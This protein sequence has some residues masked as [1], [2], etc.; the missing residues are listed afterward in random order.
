MDAYT[1]FQTSLNMRKVVVKDRID[2]SDGSVTYVVNQKETMLASEK[3]ELLQMKFKSWLFEE[4]RRRKKY[5]RYYNETFNHTRLREYDGSF[6][7]FP[8]MNPAF[9]LKPYQKNAVARIL[10]SGNTLLAHCVGAGK[11][12]EMI[13]AC[14][15]LKRLGLA[16]KPLISVP[17]TLVRQMASEFLRLYP[18]AHILVTSERDFTKN[19]RKE[20]ISRLATMEYDC[21]IMSHS[22]F[23]RIPISPDREKMILQRQLDEIL[24]G[25]DELKART[26]E[27]WT[28]KQMERE[29]KSIETELKRLQDAPK[30]D[31]ICFEELGIDCIFID[32]AHIY[33]NCKIFSKMGNIPGIT[34]AASKRA[35]D[36]LAKCQ[37]L[38]ECTP[39][40]GVILATGTPVSNSICEMY[41]MQ[42]YL[43]SDKLSQMGLQQFD[44]WAA[45]YGETTTALELAVE[46]NGYRFKTRFNRFKNLPEL[47]TMFREIADVQTRD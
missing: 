13:A 42:R 10:L 2:H 7:T 47:L 5:V 45:T 12:F 31:V 26:G 17:K 14:M 3:Q 34:S 38:N 46:G 23:E 1:I 27:H 22:Q 25:I 30:D 40:R 16:Q 21:V 39:G 20:F 35:S 19:R 18:G 24:M 36:M 6:L 11:S 37:Y 4:P 32:E 9:E 8:G 15:E 28:V 33:K 41:V 44:A 43:Q 29:R